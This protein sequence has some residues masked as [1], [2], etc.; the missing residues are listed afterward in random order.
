VLELES[1]PYSMF[2]FAMNAKQTRDKYTARLRRFFD[3]INIPGDNIEERCKL[4]VQIEKERSKT[5][6]SSNCNNDKWF[7]NNVL[8]FLQAEKDRVELKEITGATL[9]NYVKAVKLF[10]EMNDIIIAWKKIT[11][12]L[13]KGRKF[14]DDR[15]PTIEELRRIMEYPDRRIKAIVCIMASSGIRLGAWDYIRWKDIRP[16]TK[17][18]AVVAAKIIVY[19]EDAEEYFS[20]ITPEAY[21][22]VEKW[23]DYRKRSGELIDGNSSVLR[24]IWNT[25]Q[26]FRRGFIDSPRK[27]KST[28]VKRLM[29]DAIWNQ[30]LRKKLEPGKKR[31]EFQADH[32]LRKWFKTRCELAGMKP[33]NIEVLMG[34]STGISDSY[35]RATENELLEDYLKAVDFLT[36]DDKYAMAKQFFEMKESKNLDVSRLNQVLHEKYGEIDELQKSD[37]TKDDAIAALSD[38][39]QS[40]IEEVE[41]LKKRK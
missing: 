11:R 8:R 5:S 3:F 16:V 37:A 9:R 40:L 27:L 19:A 6:S 21:H 15:A 17:N 7:L 33:I 30:G 12:G 39:L 4:A 22:E 26:G 36:I 18:E 34:H 23:M 20:F 38:K 2:V 32:G 10:C 35:Y 28:G 25:K 1:D 13:P 24:N 29:E 14:A 41:N 31:H